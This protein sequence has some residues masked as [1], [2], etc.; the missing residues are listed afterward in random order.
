MSIT[1]RNTKPES[2]THFVIFV[3]L[4]CTFTWN[5]IVDWTPFSICSKKHCFSLSGSS[6]VSSVPKTTEMRTKIKEHAARRRSMLFVESVHLSGIFSALYSL[7]ATCVYLL[8]NN[9][10]RFQNGENYVAFL[11]TQK[12][13]TGCDRCL[14]Y[15]SQKHSRTSWVRTLIFTCI[16]LFIFIYSS[17]YSFIYS[18]IYLSFYICQFIF[19]LFI[20]S[21][22]FS[23]IHVHDVFLIF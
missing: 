11:L 21:F 2:S 18:F 23:F 8:T 7:N 1:I 3:I 6:N 12:S 9:T 22:F 5:S 19:F 20:H 16:W 17:V 13:S 10:G 14:L 4:L 15:R